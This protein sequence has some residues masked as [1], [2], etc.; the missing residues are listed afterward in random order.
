MRAAVSGLCS[1][2]PA[3]VQTFHWAPPQTQHS[4]SGKEDGESQTAVTPHLLQGNWT[5]ADYA[6][7]REGPEGSNTGHSGTGG[8]QDL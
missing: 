6:G 7:T 3:W 8:C 1:I 2:I 4:S 5:L